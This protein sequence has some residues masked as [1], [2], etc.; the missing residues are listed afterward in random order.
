[1]KRL[2]ALPIRSL[3][4]VLIMVVCLGTLLLS[5]VV[6]IASEAINARRALGV[7][8]STV[9]T[10]LG[11][12]STAAIAF[13]DAK[14]ANENLAS[15]Q[16]VSHVIRACLYGDQGDLFAQYAPS[17]ASA[18]AA[19]APPDTARLQVLD[20]SIRVRY[21][22]QI[23]QQKVA[24]LLVESSLASVN[25]SIWKQVQLQIGV[26][27]VAAV[28]A[29]L[30]AMRMQRLISRPLQSLSDVA[31]AIVGRHDYSLRADPAGPM[32]LSELAG[33]FN[34]L[35]ATIEQQNAELQAGRLA[36]LGRFERLRADQAVLSELAKSSAAAA[37][38]VGLL[39][40]LM[41]RR[42]LGVLKVE[43]VSVCVHSEADG[44]DF[45][46]SASLHGQ[47]RQQAG[48]GSLRLGLQHWG[49]S[50]ERYFSV[51]DCASESRLRP[52]QVQPL[53]AAGVRG[54]LWAAAGSSQLGQLSYI[55]LE[56]LDSPA[57]S[58]SSDDIAIACELADLIA[59]V[60]RD[61]RRRHA[62][63]SLRASDAY[64]KLLFRESCL[65]QGIL[66]PA[67]MRFVDCNRAALAVL[68]YSRSE[69][70]LSL[71]PADVAPALQADGQASAGLLEAR[72]RAALAGEHSVFEMQLLRAE[73][74]SW[75]A[76]VHLDRFESDTATLVQ[77][78]FIDISAR[79]QAQRAMASL[80]QELESRVERRTAAL[81][82][83][84]QQLSETLDTLQK[85]KDEL[86]RNERLSSLGS[87]V[88]GV[89]HE[90]NTPI[91]NS[92]VVASTLQDGSEALALEV[93]S[94]T[95]R[96][97]GM[98][99]FLEMATESSSL[100]MRNLQ[101]A[102]EL[103]SRFKQ[104][105]V[106]QTSGQRRQFELSE[107]IEEV[108]ETLRPQFRITPHRLLTQIPAGI[109]LDSWPGDLERVVAQLVV[110]TLVHAH[111][112]SKPGCTVIS[113]VLHEGGQRVRLVVADDGQGIEA[114]SLARIFDPFFTTRLGSGSNGLGLHTVFSLVTKSL[115]GRISVESTPGLGA[116]FI[117]D[118]P[119]VAPL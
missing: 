96:R 53:L 68:G 50:G 41:C 75:D 115:G 98:A 37:A 119:C 32:E 117:V 78:S 10:L 13:D 9:A 16:A 107:T 59:L 118:I 47:V 19:G 5:S 103:V 85:T 88:A 57:R 86:V 20:A 52:E 15:L 108:A 22:I 72:I 21:P 90:L 105:A 39:A 109:S 12:R 54:F 114:K 56:S 66:D 83:A 29:L 42:L 11:N 31:K 67:A 49:A 26:V 73:Q 81:S 27:L 14:T 8:L 84:N 99:S 34:R 80:N 63:R 102:A 4:I 113:A 71:R 94:G 92:L 43:R 61:S 6:H 111:Q 101:R 112:D 58:W 93:A 36:A 70:L 104:L 3:G 25:A 106:D 60:E 69:Q 44:G 2:A 82:D 46:E 89:A 48:E 91:G 110:N 18:C 79:V 35:M 95:L 64:N 33:A 55:C 65:A 77:F 45:F 100:L 62:E 116:S 24:V 76:E 51:S 30:V 74:P 7:E 23:D 1:M 38:D 87:L 97:S 40:G 28:L 17:S